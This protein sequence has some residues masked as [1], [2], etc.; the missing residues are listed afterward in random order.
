MLDNQS[1]C[2]IWNKDV[3]QRKTGF[4]KIVLGQHHRLY[5]CRG[6]TFH[7]FVYLRCMGTPIVTEKK[8]VRSQVGC[9]Q[10]VIVLSNQEVGKDFKVI[11]FTRSNVA[12]INIVE[13]CIWRSLDVLPLVRSRLNTT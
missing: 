12:E 9:S 11:C 7:G 13:A 10:G 6:E 8:W 2:I 1:Q 4:L 3:T 5:V